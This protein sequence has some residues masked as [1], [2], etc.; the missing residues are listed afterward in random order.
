MSFNND[1][2][3]FYK[4]LLDD[5][6]TFVAVLEPNGNLIFVNNT[7][8]I[9]AGLKL[10]E[11]KGKKFY[12]A[13]WWTHSDET[14]NAIKHDIEEC[15]AGK[16]MLHQIQAKAVDGTLVWLEYSM[17]PI[18]DDNGKVKYLVPEGRDITEHKQKEELLRRSQKMD[19]LGKLT[20]GIAHDYNNM[21]GIIM[22]Y[23]ELLNNN[24]P[25]DPKLTKYTKHIKRAVERGTALTR[26]LLAFTR[27]K[28][29]EAK[30]ININSQL[31]ELQHML[32]KS[33]TVKVTLLYD[34]ADELWATEM[35]P[36]DLEDVIINMSINSMH[37]MES[38]GQLSFRTANQHISEDDAQQLQ[39]TA[40]DYVLLSIAD[41]GCGM[42]N[43]TKERV[44]EPFFSTKDEQ[45]TGLGMSQVYSFVERSGGK[46]EV[47]SEPNKGTRFVLYFPRSHKEITHLLTTSSDTK[48]N[49]RGNETLLV[50]DDEQAMLDLG[51]EILITQGYQVLTA[52]D[53]EKALAVLDTETVDL[54]ITDVIMPHMDGYQLASHV[55][56]KYPHIKIQI[57]SGFESDRHK[58]MANEVLRNQLLY[59]PYS[60]NE[61]LVRVRNLLDDKTIT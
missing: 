35:D 45:G 24:L 52:I 59:K 30:V 7:P 5:M 25:D 51:Y 27:Q 32:E 29:T 57:V 55:Q 3:S 54:M 60:S 14:R 6:V 4:A 46:I 36:G 56:K 22:G 8:L 19:A 33:L 15:A 21:L 12:D 58:V 41:T 40:G 13:P 23:A 34:L 39:I 37:A 28:T 47:F 31:H 53:G 26:K 43:E 10:E 11:V 44:F 1:N 20:G 49:L 42:D 16:S 18:L 48:R 9:M 2:D 17:H 61:L 38:G 50:V